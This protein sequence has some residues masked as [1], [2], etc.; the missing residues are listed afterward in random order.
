MIPT[1][2]AFDAVAQIQ[3]NGAIEMALAG[4]LVG[5]FFAAAQFARK[6]VDTPPE[7]WNWYKFGATVI[8]GLAVGAILGFQGIDIT[9]ALI[10]EQLAA[11][12]GTIVIVESILKAIVRWLANN[13][14]IPKFE[15]FK[16]QYKS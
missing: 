12:G 14:Y 15:A 10:V 11:L 9:Y 2:L 5:A 1:R 6:R 16:S 13:G 8:V 3:A 7:K 4:A